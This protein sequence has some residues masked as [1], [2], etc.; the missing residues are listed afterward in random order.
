MGQFN[1]SPKWI[2]TRLL[3]AGLSPD[4]TA[5]RNQVERL[6]T[7]LDQLPPVRTAA[8]HRSTPPAPDFAINR[9]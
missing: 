3:R 9:S 1:I 4:D 8:D 7:A 5:I 6:R 2:V